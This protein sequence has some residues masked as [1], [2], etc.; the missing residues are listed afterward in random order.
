[1]MALI[2]R[3]A[4]CAAMNDGELTDHHYSHIEQRDLIARQFFNLNHDDPEIQDKHA[5]LSAE[6]HAVDLDPLPI[7]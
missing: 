1:M 7:R 6:F 3:N 2:D 4:F 5:D